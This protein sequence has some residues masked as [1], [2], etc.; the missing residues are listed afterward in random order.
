MT[1]S[2]TFVT[3]SQG[4]I[5]EV[6]TILG[7]KLDICDL[8][9]PE[10]QAINVETVVSTKVKYAYEALGKKPVLVEDTGLYI[11]AW[12][13][14]PGAL[15][16]WFIE[17]PRPEGICKMLHQFESRKASAET[18]VATYDGSLH[19]FRGKVSGNIALEPRGKG[20]FGWDSIFIPDGQ[21]KTF[22][23]MPLTEKLNY[24]MRRD[25]FLKMYQYYQDLT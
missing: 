1:L 12:N 7:F 22:G 21:T 17:G 5:R 11:E 10:V 2:L 25:A 4:K 6:E 16:K 3:H 9:L 13:G 14:L 8:D 15:I 24:S 23:E 19:I 18:I 20:G